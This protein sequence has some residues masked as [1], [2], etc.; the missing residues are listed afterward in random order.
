VLRGWAV[1]LEVL[2]VQDPTDPGR[3][4]LGI[5]PEGAR[6][7]KHFLDL[8]G[9]GVRDLCPDGD[10]LLVLAGP[11][12]ALSGPVRVHRW[13]GAARTG[14]V[15][16]DTGLPVET[17]LRHGEGDDHAEG[18]TL[19]R[20][21]PRDPRARL[22]VVYDVPAPARRPWPDTVLA[23]RLRIGTTADAADAADTAAA[24]EPA[25]HTADPVDPADD[26]DGAAA[27]PVDPVPAPPASP[28]GAGD[29]GPDLGD[30]ADDRDSPSTPDPG[31][32]P[33]AE[34]GDEHAGDHG[35]EHA[36]DHGDDGHGAAGVQHV[37]VARVTDGPTP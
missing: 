17:V 24:P 12:M 18:I 21:D 3:L 30:D 14:P 16:R 6:Y 1:V 20:G 13:R 32:W 29:P 7:R 10:D 33:D 8:G 5:F 37:S 2:P 26:P 15:V 11:T 23:D 19:L 22:L 28:A 25:E 34:H 36:G 35:G 9:L 4:A 31:A 27:D